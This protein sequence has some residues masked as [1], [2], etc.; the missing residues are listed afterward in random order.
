MVSRTDPGDFTNTTLAAT[1]MNELPRGMLNSVKLTSDSTGTTSTEVILSDTVV[2][3]DARRLLFMATCTLRTDT[4]GGLQAR[5]DL[6]GTQIQRKNADTIFAGSDTFITLFTSK[7]VSAGSHT[8]ELITGVSG[9]GGN[10][11]TAKANG[12]TG[13][14]GVAELVVIDCGPQLS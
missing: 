10:T 1:D 6:G 3:T 9:G 13:T 7:N 4:A 12:E 11:V 14:H 2:L 5:L 8:I